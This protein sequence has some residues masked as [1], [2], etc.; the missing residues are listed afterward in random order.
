MKVAIALA[1]AASSIATVVAQ[2]PVA[3]YG[4]CGGSGYTGSTTC[5][6]GYVCQ[7]SSQWYSQCVPSGGTTAP[8]AKPTTKQPTPSTAT[9]TTA[10]TKQ[11]T[12]STSVPTPAGCTLSGTYVS[13][14]DVSSC[15]SVVISSLQ[16]PL[17]DGATVTF[18]GTT[19]FG[20]KLWDG[21][22]ILLTGT[23]LKVTGPGT[24]NGQGEWY[25]PQGQSVSRPV[26]FRLTHVDQSTL[27]GFT[28][29]NSPY[30]TF[31]VL[32]SVNTLITG[33]TL[34]SK[35]GDSQAK[36]TDGFDLSRNTGVNI[37]HNII[38]NQDDC[39]AMQSSTNTL[40]A[41]NSCTGGHGISIGSIGGPAV[42]SS[43]TVNGLTV[44]NNKIIDN[45]NGLRIKTIIDLKGLVTNVKYIDNTLTNVKNAIVM[46]SDYSKAK[47]GYVGTPTSQV[48]ISDITISGLT[49]TATNLY[50][51]VANPSVVSNWNWSGINVQA[52]SKGS[53]KGQPSG[54]TCA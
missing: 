33:L 17:K 15:S 52:T 28:I 45:T 50:D 51:V 24:L 26:F 12:P 22:L 14:T 34:D 7:V 29:H 54:V 27:S 44:N 4:Q 49:G 30:R 38:F 42:D 37:T 25:W 3:A 40:F 18:T 2:T 48:T 6:Q 10:P 21:P 35:A 46:H 8:T 36:N 5:V 53:C 9:P 23:N 20:T 32:N 11:P 41:Y 47:G 39:L 31:S 43:D 1:F 13:G 16:V 19:T